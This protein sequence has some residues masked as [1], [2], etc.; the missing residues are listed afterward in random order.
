LAASV[1]AGAQLKIAILVSEFNIRGGTHKQVHRLADYLLAQGHEVTICTK[2]FAPER[3]YPGVEKFDVY[4]ATNRR[5]APSSRISSLIVSLVADLRLALRV[6]KHA[7]VVNIHDSGFLG[8][9]LFL[10]VLAPGKRIVWQINDLPGIFNLRGLSINSVRSFLRAV[11][12][13]FPRML[14]RL[15]ACDVDKITVNV[16]K[17]A[18]RVRKH[19]N[20]DAEVIHCGV[21]IRNTTEAW[22]ERTSSHTVN[23]ISVG[24]FLPYRN[25]ESILRAQ[26][27]LADLYNIPSRLV[28]IGSTERAPEYAE[29]V[30]SHARQL[31][32]ECRILGEIDENALMQVYSQSDIFLFVNVDQSWGLAVFEAMNLG[33]PVIVSQSVGAVELLNAGVDAEIVDPKNENAIANA[34]RKLHV[35][36]DLYT[37]RRRAGYKATLQMTWEKLYCQRVEKILQG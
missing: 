10:K 25:Y 16:T 31:D 37:M 18:E 22:N 2:Y 17:N 24:V 12:H 32:V 27:A 21:D 7:D 14:T 30:A 8:F 15:M 3:C 1:E 20:A 23:L 5:D 6:A 28:I 29:Q 11:I 34:I 9:W 4:A 35:D 36:R 33:L 19:L 13:P 26:R